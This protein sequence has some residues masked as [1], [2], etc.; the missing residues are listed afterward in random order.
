M[1]KKAKNDQKIA[2]SIV[3]VSRHLNEPVKVTQLAKMVNLSSSYFWVLF[4]QRTGYAPVD[5]LIRLRMCQACHLLNSTNLKVK[6]IAATLGY[7][8]PFYFSRVFKSIH[9]VAP[10]NYRSAGSKAESLLPEINLETRPN[11]RVLGEPETPSP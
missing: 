1:N 3:F 2:R 6:K 4:K 7:K 5:Y 8:D 10:T 11:P 9:G